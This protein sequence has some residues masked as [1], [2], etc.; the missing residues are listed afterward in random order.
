MLFGLYSSFFWGQFTTDINNRLAMAM[1]P[2]IILPATYSLYRLSHQ[3][4]QPSGL[5]VILLLAA[6]LIYYWPTAGEQLLLR[7]NALHYTNERV[8]HCL[9]QQY[10]MKNEKLLL[11]S[12]RP[13]LYV[14]HG[15][16]SVGYRYAME[17]QKKLNVLSN[18]YYDHIMV[19]QKCD[20]ATHE[21]LPNNKLN[22]GFVLS[23][24]Y[25]INVSP[26][27]YLRISEVTCLP[28][29]SD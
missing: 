7:E 4:F 29:A 12:D 6:Q 14:I 8:T 20:L 3:P 10:D 5:L 9:Y 2:F 16:G 13:N 21:V 19:L 22:D 28:P 25:R 1:L 11:I 18:I 23:E 17:N 15:I 24:L 27:Y 26:A